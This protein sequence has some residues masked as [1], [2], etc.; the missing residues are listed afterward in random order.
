MSFVIDEG[1]TLC[2]CAR[3]ASNQMLEQKT[4]VSSELSNVSFWNNIEAERL[5]FS[6][7]KRTKA[8]FTKLIA[9]TKFETKAVYLDMDCNLP[10]KINYDTPH[11]LGKDRI[12]GAVA[13]NDLYPNKNVLIIDAG[14]SITYDLVSSENA[15]EGGAISLGLKMRF[16]ALHNYTAQLPLITD[17]STETP[18]T[19]KSTQQCM[20]S[21]VING[22]K[23]E[24]KALIEKYQSQF[25]DLIIL[26]TGGD[27][28]LFETNLKNNIFAQP[29]LV[30]HG[31]NKILA[32]NAPL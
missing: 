27:A 25:P 17:F 11:S 26:V 22:I 24:I 1:N 23:A 6:S 5:I 13:A 30:M 8:D 3:F 10:I 15:F 12:A 29:N 28:F 21:G 7:V 32:H 14:T 18:L 31:L 20:M 19:G 16:Q 4:L 9:N 2:K